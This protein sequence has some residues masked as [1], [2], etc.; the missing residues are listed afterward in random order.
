MS[1][2]YNHK[3]HFILGVEKSRNRNYRYDAIIYNSIDGKKHRLE[4]GNKAHPI[5]TDNSRLGYYK[6]NTK[7][8]AT[9]K[10]KDKENY[11]RQNRKAILSCNLCKQYLEYRFFFSN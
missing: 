8:K 6:Y 3:T 10:I 9:G 11:I 5:Y 7:Y 4:I 1:I 2:S